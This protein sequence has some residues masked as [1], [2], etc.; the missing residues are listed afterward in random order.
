MKVAVL[1]D[2]HGN[3]AALERVADDILHW[4][5]D[6]VIVNGDVVN[7]GPRPLA[8]W[9]FVQAQAKENG[10]HIL[11]GNHED[12]VL[13]FLEDDAS[14]LMVDEK[15][16]HAFWTFRRLNG[17]VEELRPLPNH[18]T[19]TAPDNSKLC[20]THASMNSN[21]DG[22]NATAP[23]EKIRQQIGMAPAVFC[24]GHTHKSFIRHV[25][26]TMV[27]NSGSVG[28]PFDGD[29]RASYAQ[30]TWQKNEWS[31]KIIR[32]EYD[33]EQA[34]RDFEESGFLDGGGP[35]VKIML[36]EFK[37]AR[38]HMYNWYRTYFDAVDKGEISFTK[39]VDAYLDS[40][41]V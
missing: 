38:S 28:V 34:E 31:S 22:I 3:L 12:Y 6:A 14:S 15:Q 40:C 37:N 9:R 17:A 29:W 27:V 2:I 20:L 18:H 1:S 4:Q 10:W 8:C 24:T 11:R 39:S 21:R 19:F 25:D 23:K 30:L 16:K 33:R 41:C 13:S 5:P 35:F 26:Q 7:R 36:H 32:L